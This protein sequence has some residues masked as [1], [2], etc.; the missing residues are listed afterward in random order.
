MSEAT[1]NDGGTAFPCEQGHAPDGNW[2]QTFDPGMS[3]LEWYAG[4][5]LPAVIDAY[6]KAN[7]AGSGKPAVGTNH[8][9]RN[10]AII[11]FE[12]AEA[13]IAEESKR[14]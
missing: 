11:S 4:K 2:N 9:P 1:K 8:L 14:R 3:L 6:V 12:I 10:C 7:D 5:A 13:M